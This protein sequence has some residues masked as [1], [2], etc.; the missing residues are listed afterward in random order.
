MKKYIRGETL[1]GIVVVALVTLLMTF[2]I[3]VKEPIGDDVRSSFEGA[4]TYYLDEYPDV[5]GRR[6]TSLTQ[7]GSLLRFVYGNWSGRIPGYM[8]DYIGYLLPQAAT[9]VITAVIYTLVCLLA[10]RVLLGNMRTVLEHPLYFVLLYLMLFWTRPDVFYTHMWT[11]TSIYVAGTMLCLLYWNMV[12]SD[13]QTFGS[14]VCLQLVGFL[15]GMA[16]EVLSLCVIVVILSRWLIGVWYEKKPVRM[17]LV[18]SGLMIGYAFGFFAPGNFNRVGQSHDVITMDLI[19]KMIR[20]MKVHAQIVLSG[21]RWMTKLILGFLILAVVSFVY[22]LLSGG[23]LR[24][25]CRE[26]V[27]MLLGGLTSILVW[28]LMPRVPSYSMDLWIVLVVLVLVKLVHSAIGNIRLMPVLNKAAAVLLL[29]FVMSI[30]HTEVS[31]VAAVSQERTWRIQAAAE[32]NLAEVVV[33]RYPD[34][35]SPYRY[36]LQHWNDQK[37]YDYDYQREYYQTHVI[38][39]TEGNVNS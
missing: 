32:Q 1:V 38:V 11:M 8:M 12:Q 6:I 19:S 2:V 9:A 34:W 21:D 20:S 35:L 14:I 23:K 24:E 15:A 3:L 30:C 4:L 16:H 7:V 39:E 37:E 31:T 36:P 25:L 33:P 13:G 10:L 29:C 27:P 17:L 5:L 26:T 18:H 22:L 28:S